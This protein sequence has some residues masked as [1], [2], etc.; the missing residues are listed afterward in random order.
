ML[1]LVA[2]SVQILVKSDLIGTAEETA[3]AWNE[4]NDDLDNMND[5]TLINGSE[6]TLKN[7]LEDAGVD[8]E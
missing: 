4:A 8:V 7:Y 6:K 3:N 5:K 2:V 1:I